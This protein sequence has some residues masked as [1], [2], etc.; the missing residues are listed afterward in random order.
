MTA[1]AVV[2]WCSRLQLEWGRQQQFLFLA[3]LFM[4]SFLQRFSPVTF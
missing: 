1:A 4:P 2:L 3:V